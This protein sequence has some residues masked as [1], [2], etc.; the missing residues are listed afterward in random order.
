MI[1][2]LLQMSP[3]RTRFPVRNSLPSVQASIIR[4]LVEYQHN[5][6]YI[7]MAMESGAVGSNT[8]KAETDASIVSD[9]IS[10]SDVPSPNNATTI[11]PTPISTTPKTLAVATRYCAQ[12]F[13]RRATGGDI[14][15]NLLKSFESQLSRFK[16][17]AG[18]L[19]VFTPGKGS[20][21]YRLRHD[22]ETKDILISM[23]VRLAEKV[24]SRTDQEPVLVDHNHERL[25]LGAI[26]ASSL[27]SASSS[28][29][30]V[31]DSDH[32]SEAGK[33]SHVDEDELHQPV[34]R[35][36]EAIIS[37]LY[38]FSTIIRK[39]THDN[40]K[41]RV[42]RYI[43]E[44]LGNLDL[45]E[46]DTHVRWQLKRPFGLCPKLNETSPLFERLVDGALYRRKKILYHAAHQEKLEYGIEET[47]SAPNS[48]SK[49]KSMLPMTEKNELPIGGD[50]KT[51]RDQK[52]VTFIETT[53]SIARK[54]PLST[55]GK[56]VVLTGVT[57]SQQA[58]R[59]HLDIPPIPATIGPSMS[60]IKCPYCS[61][62]ITE[63]LGKVDSIQN[64]R[65]R[66]ASTN[67]YQYCRTDF[68]RIGAMF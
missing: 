36:I 14:P 13:V 27:S 59:Q 50:S 45:S 10:Q 57:M 43:N 38:R 46:L 7:T 56:S 37:R 8:A 62:L 34:L 40:E 15:R 39:P 1:E 26:E 47:F 6:S 49:T 44:Q 53:A 22:A 2:Q 11:D 28:S 32:D 33:V 64:N 35:E 54:T 51:P 18:Y 30:L 24:Q 58:R 63:E 3:Y 68:I 20:A 48:Q 65:W 52:A 31:L 55:F 5:S 61:H 19:G 25:S 9:Q 60:E 4:T 21:D 17:W 67:V 16:I 12:N 42:Q 66:L 41:E 23:L 29:S